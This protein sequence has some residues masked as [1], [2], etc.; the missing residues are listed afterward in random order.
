MGKRANDDF[1]NLFR[2]ELLSLFPNAQSIFVTSINHTLS[3]P[4][5]LSVL[6]SAADFNL[7]K[8][9]VKTQFGK[10]M[11]EVWSSEQATLKEQFAE[12]DFEIEYKEEKIGY[13]N[14]QM[15]VITR[16]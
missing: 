11:N 1:S 9:I 3:M 2:A 14:W 5:L 16:K 4:N 8:I 10:W 6:V 12:N 15:F 13:D 7:N